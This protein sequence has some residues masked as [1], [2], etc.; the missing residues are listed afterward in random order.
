MIRVFA[1]SNNASLNYNWPSFKT[2]EAAIRYIENN[3]GEFENQEMI[4]IVD[5]ENMKTR[6]I[7]AELKMTFS[8]L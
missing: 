4:A 5:F 1:E 6:F 8:E 2:V 3:S 7:R